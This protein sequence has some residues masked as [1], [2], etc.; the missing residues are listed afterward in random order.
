MRFLSRQT[1]HISVEK[2][3][4]MIHIA[5]NVYKSTVQ[6]EGTVYCTC[7]RAGVCGCWC[8]LFNMTHP[9]PLAFP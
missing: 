2:K 4:L 8:V 5:L 6:A 3:A 1:I 7:G 9:S